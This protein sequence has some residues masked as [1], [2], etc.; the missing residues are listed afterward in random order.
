MLS[1]ET[2]GT[3]AHRDFGSSSV[4]PAG[5]AIGRRRYIPGRERPRLVV[6]RVYSCR[7]PSAAVVGVGVDAVGV[8]VDA[9]GVEDDAVKVGDDAVEVGVDAVG[10]GFML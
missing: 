3:A 5:R 8:R 4:I 6:R 9:V 10:V 1:N 2:C 7:S